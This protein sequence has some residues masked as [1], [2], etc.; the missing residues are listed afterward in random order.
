M[1][2]SYQHL[3]NVDIT[4]LSVVTIYKIQQFVI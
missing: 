3:D 1:G 4:H 2:G